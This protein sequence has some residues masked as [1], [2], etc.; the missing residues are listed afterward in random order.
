[1][2]RGERHLGRAD[3]VEVVLGGPVDVHLVGRQE[4]GAVHRLL[5]HEHRRDHGDEA[6]RRPGCPCA[7]R[8]S[9]N[10]DE[11]E[12]AEQVDEPRARCAHRALDVEHAEQLAERHVVAR[13]EVERRRGVVVAADLD[14]VLVGEAVGALV[15]RARSA[16]LASSSVSCGLGLRQLRLQLLQLGADRRDLGDQPLLLVALRARRSPSTRGSARRAAPRRAR[17]ARAGARRRRAARRRR[18]PRFR[19]ASA[20]AE[21]FRVVPDRFD[22]EHRASHLDLVG[23]LLLALRRRGR[24]GDAACEPT[25]PTPRPASMMLCPWKT[26]PSST[27]SVF[28]VMLPSI[29]PPRARCALPFTTMLPLNRPATLTF[30]ARMSAST[31]LCGES[32]TSPS[33]LIWPLTCPSIREAPG[34]H[35]VALQARAGTDDRD[36]TVLR[37][38][39]SFRFGGPRRDRSTAPPRRRRVR[40]IIAPAPPRILAHRLPDRLL[41]FQREVVACWSPSRPASRTRASPAVR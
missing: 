29:R 1:M 27:T 3:Q 26:P 17:S 41:L 40:Q 24:A 15:V 12:V 35:D 36:L 22:V 32:A 4:P 5:A 19:G 23:F 18:R 10:C 39:R 34:R 11:H 20:V 31:W 13:L 38:V 16:S 37:H 2:Q 14:G 28:D 8:T 21:R 30:C 25:S 33:A 6:P 7:L 9:A